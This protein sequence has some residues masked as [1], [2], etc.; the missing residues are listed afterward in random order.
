M[1]TEGHI[2]GWT[3]LPVRSEFFLPTV[4]NVLAHRGSFDYL[5]MTVG[6][7]K[8]R[9]PPVE[10]LPSPPADLQTERRFEAVSLLPA[11]L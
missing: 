9:N 5:D 1:S 11:D 7:S 6:E 2:P 3:F 4:S 8:V 10:V